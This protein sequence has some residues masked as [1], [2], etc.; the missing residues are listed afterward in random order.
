MEPNVLTTLAIGFALGMEHALDA[1]HVVAV[2]TLV[3]QHKSLRRASLVGVVWGLGH[4]T[5]LFLV[6]LAVILFR[7]RIP[8]WLAQ[9]MELVVGLV[10]VGLGASIVRGYLRGRVHAHPHQHGSDAHLHFHS[11]AMAPGH[12]HEHP[13]LR[14]RQSLLVGMVHGLAGSAALMLLVLATIRTPMLGILYIL[15]FGAGSILGMLGISTL[16]G[17][18]CVLTAERSAAIHRK[19]RIAVGSGSVVYGVWILAQVGLVQGL[20]RH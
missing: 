14:H 8:E 6:G 7:L 19:L 20:L 18:P 9:S 11:H 12:D 17:V 16:L 13:L 2:S 3:S 15:V 10:L 1:D 4:T 5:T